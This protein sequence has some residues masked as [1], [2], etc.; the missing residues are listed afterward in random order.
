MPDSAMSR[1]SYTTSGLTKVFLVIPATFSFCVNS[2]EAK[3][4]C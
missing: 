3:S 1:I 2:Q 4:K